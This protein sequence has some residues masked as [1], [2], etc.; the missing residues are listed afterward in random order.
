MHHFNKVK[1]GLITVILTDFQTL[2]CASQSIPNL[3]S[4][5]FDKHRLI[6]IVFGR[7]HQNIFKSD[8]PIQLSVSITFTYFIC[9]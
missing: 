6:L 8:V 7:Q 9:F 5:G 1:N 2:H 4:C 3:A